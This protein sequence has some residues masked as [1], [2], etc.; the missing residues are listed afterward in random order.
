MTIR[1][2]LDDRAAVYTVFKGL[3]A[4]LVKVRVI[5]FCAFRRTQR[6]DLS[7]SSLC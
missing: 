4:C 7:D 3:R 1:V 2:P 5:P 6:E